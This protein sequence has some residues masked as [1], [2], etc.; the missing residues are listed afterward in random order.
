MAGLVPL[1]GY[2]NTHFY[3]AQ[4]NIEENAYMMRRMKVAGHKETSIVELKGYG[5][6][7]SSSQP[8]H[9]YWT[10]DREF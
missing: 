3:G 1:S 6:L 9:S 10:E 2:T 7:S 5:Q 8:F 4:K